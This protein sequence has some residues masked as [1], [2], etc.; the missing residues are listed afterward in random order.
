MADNEN[1]VNISIGA[2]IND[3]ITTMKEGAS[4]VQGAMNI[5]KNSA[6]V[7]S[8]AFEGAMGAIREQ[9]RRTEQQSEQSSNKIQGSVGKLGSFMSGVL[10][11]IVAGFSVKAAM[12]AVLGFADA[13][14]K[15]GN[16]SQMIGTTSTALSRL[17]AVAIPMGIAAESVDKGMVKLSRTLVDA[18]R[19]GEESAAAF[20]A[21]GI[22]GNDLKNLS[23]PDVMSKIADKFK[24]SEDGA[25]K[26][27]VAQQL[28]GRAGAELIPFLNQGSDAI[29]E[30]GDEAE[31]LNAVMGE[32]AVAAGEAL[33]A[34]WD[35]L[36]MQ[37]V[38]LKNTLAQALAPTLQFIAESFT[39]DSGAATDFGS[40]FKV[41]GT[42]VIATVS[43]IQEAWNIIKT[44]VRSITIAISSVFD[45]VG[46]AATGDFS[47]AKAALATGR[48]MITDE[49]TDLVESSGKLSDKFSRSME[50][51]WSDA[52]KPKST[53]NQARGATG[54]LDFKE[55]DSVTKER[56]AAGKKAAQ[57]AMQAARDKFEYEMELLRTEMSEQQKGAEEKI[58]I[59]AR[60]VEAVKA[61]YGDQSREYARAL[62]EQVKITQEV[63]A[64]KRRIQDVAL[65]KAREH[66]IFEINLA[67]EQAN[68]LLATGQIT[69]VQK[70]EIERRSEE[71]I[72]A[73]QLSYLEAR[74]QLMASE[75]QEV[76][77]INGEIEK[78]QQDHQVKMAQGNVAQF[79]ANK[80][81]WDGYFQSITDG[82][83]NA[84]QGMV[85]QG[86]TLQQA[87]GNV[88]QNILGQLI[89]TG[90]KMAANW[91]AAQLAM[92]SATVAGA[93]VRT[94]AEV[95]SAK[96]STMAN[97]GAAIK[98]I[99]TKAV[100]VFANV[101]NAIAGI[102]YVG[103][104][105]APVM[106]V[107]AGA[108]IVGLVGK[109][110]SAEQGWERVPYDGAQAVLH[111]EE[112]VL[113]APLAE[114]IRG[115]VEN[116]N[117]GGGGVNVYA[118]D[119]RDVQRYFDDNSDV[120]MR[121]LTL[122]SANNPGGF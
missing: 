100:E 54:E 87:L 82:F 47:G 63:E 2:Q 84:I 52:A 50:G 104:F 28:F 62:R 11:S 12:D 64:E 117:K 88:F 17:H 21:V 109:V 29:K 56:D 31:R 34:A 83:G 27:A 8:G 39:E 60:V 20:E 4:G 53:G 106:A 118:M 19:G 41:V 85:F 99:M 96:T 79:D 91:I 57:E 86:L 81:Q 116:G 70:V 101:Y 71:Q 51:M 119:R 30:Q 121:T 107:A 76:E 49:L 32:D 59:E 77:R 43:V 14:E 61:Q 115:M 36:T 110:A 46:K 26:A 7:T 44:V 35:K 112:M 1:N 22:K 95:T 98:N 103:P 113:P 24:D 15:L 10:G 108:T 72:Y 92:T 89:Q 97:A 23:L 58:Q 78:L 6:A 75:P 122:A 42:I 16:T 45:A 66:G 25:T 93:A 80:A 105:L 74:R 13:A 68:L 67:K 38:G 3:L 73:L 48:Q 5:I 111:K 18:R 114:G 37:G 33:D 120:Y 102:P 40:V 65:V 94:T 90:V 9:F 55:K 69:G